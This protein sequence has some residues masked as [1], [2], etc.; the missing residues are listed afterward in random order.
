MLPELLK[1]V[2]D[3]KVSFSCVV[4]ACTFSSWTA[5]ALTHNDFICEQA[6]SCIYYGSLS[7][8]FILLIQ[9]KI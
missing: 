2:V 3:L 7:L 5:F 9:L 4:F 6:E 1:W 8:C